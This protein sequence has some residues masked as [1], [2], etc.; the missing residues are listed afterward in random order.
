VSWSSTKRR[1]RKG[2]A[3]LQLSSEEQTQTRCDRCGMST[4]DNGNRLRVGFLAGHQETPRCRTLASV[5]R[6]SN[7]GKRAL[8]SSWEKILTAIDVPFER[9]PVA[10]SAEL[11]DS[12]LAPDRGRKAQPVYGP[13]V[14]ARVHEMATLRVRYPKRDVVAHFTAALV[15]RKT[16]AVLA[17]RGTPADLELIEACKLVLTVPT[18]ARKFLRAACPVDFARANL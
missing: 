10:W 17:H 9:A 11:P 7:S 16:L 15:V 12:Y 2:A 3:F 6:M 8:P 4:L 18:A 1:A 5:L 13:W 14:S